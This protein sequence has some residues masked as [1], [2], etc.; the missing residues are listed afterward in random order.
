MEQSL[1]LLWDAETR[2]R[3]WLTLAT[4]DLHTGAVLGRP[5]S[6]DHSSMQRTMPVDAPIPKNRRTTPIHPRGDD[7]PPTPLTRHIW[8]CKGVMAMR[9]IHEMEKEGPMANDFS[10]VTKIHQYMI[11]L[12]QR[13]PAPL[14]FENPDTRFDNHPDCAWIVKGRTSLP[15][16]FCYNFI[17]LHRPYVFTRADSRYEALKA[18]LDMLVAQR[19]HFSILEPRHYHNFA[20]FFG[21]F[22]AVIM[23]ASIYILFPRDNLDLVSKAAWHFRWSVDRFETIAPKNRLAHAALGVLYALYTRLK[24]AINIESICRGRQQQDDTNNNNKR[25]SNGYVVR[26]SNFEPASTIFSTSGAA[27]SPNDMPT[28]TSSAGTITSTIPLSTHSGSSLTPP[29]SMVAAPAPAGDGSAA[30]FGQMDWSLPADFDFSAMPP[31]YPMGD[32]AYNDLTGT[33]D[34][35]ALYPLPP[36]AATYPNHLLNGGLQQQPPAASSALGGTLS[37][38][39]DV[40]W[41]FGGD[42]GHDTI[43]SLLNQFP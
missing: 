8:M 35:A 33:R 20:L 1:E 5:T 24:K 39:A 9:E 22:D 30:L 28:V 43:W 41:Q 3:M 32:L 40:P 26:A 18:S 34:A 7:D 25:S 19:A 10:K 38:G 17:A 6:I 14:R 29:D 36:A 37:A 2:R 11:E 23:L 15:H 4:W 21:T 16:I 12:E 27:N 42:F 31:M 13:L